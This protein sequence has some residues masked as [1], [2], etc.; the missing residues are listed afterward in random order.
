[1]S[2]L[3]SGHG[4]NA[5]HD[6]LRYRLSLEDNKAAG[7]ADLGNCQYDD[8][9][10]RLRINLLCYTLIGGCED[11]GQVFNEMRSVARLFQLLDYCNDDVVVDAVCIDLASD[12][13]DIAW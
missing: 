7:F 6:R 12:T 13:Y 1:M 10:T 2:S 5:V 9:W 4:D 11:C 3:A 8:Q